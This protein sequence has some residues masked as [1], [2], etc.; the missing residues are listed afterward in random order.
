VCTL[1]CDAGDAGVRRWFAALVSLEMNRILRL[2]SV[3]RATHLR[4]MTATGEDNQQNR[5]E[6][7]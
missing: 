4:S 1:E 7:S 2:P 5:Y 3:H 6:N